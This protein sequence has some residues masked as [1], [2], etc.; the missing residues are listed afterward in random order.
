MTYKELAEERDSLQYRINAY[1]TILGRCQEKYPFEYKIT[2][3]KHDSV[4][5]EGVF[6]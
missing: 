4:I 3:Y 1:E 2:Y 6:R 5:V